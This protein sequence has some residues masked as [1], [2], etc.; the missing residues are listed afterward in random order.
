MVSGG[1]NLGKGL[2]GKSPIADEFER[3]KA[4]LMGAG[5]DSLTVLSDIIAREKIECGLMMNGRFVGAWTPRHYAD[6]ATKVETYNTYANAGSHMVPRE[7]QHEIIP[8]SIT[9]A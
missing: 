8:R 4:A 1:T 2:G 7:R 5:A 3:N 9:G 6:M